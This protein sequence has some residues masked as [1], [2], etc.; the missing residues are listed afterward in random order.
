MFDYIFFRQ[1]NRDL[2]KKHLQENGIQA[3]LSE[4]HDGMLVSIDE[5][6]SD[7]LLDEIEEYYDSLM[8]ECENIIANEEGQQHLSTAG[9]VLNLKDGSSIQTVVDPSLINRMLTVLSMEELGRFVQ[10]I[11]DAV[12][13]PDKR[14]FCQQAMSEHSPEG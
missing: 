11:V 10:T 8:T 6:I 1:E 3:E 7:D 14:P 4:T 2:F 13:N 5:D 9:I 12:E